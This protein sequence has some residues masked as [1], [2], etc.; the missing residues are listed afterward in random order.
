[1][2]IFDYFIKHIFLTAPTRVPTY[3]QNKPFNKFFIICVDSYAM[4]EYK[5]KFWIRLIEI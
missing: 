3:E 2:W 1:M 4:V 5:K